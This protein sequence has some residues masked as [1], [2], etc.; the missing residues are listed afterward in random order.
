MLLPLENCMLDNSPNA[1][2]N[3]LPDLLLYQPQEIKVFSIDMRLSN[4]RD[5]FYGVMGESYW[6]RYYPKA[7]GHDPYSN[8]LFIEY[9]YSKN[10]IS[11][12]SKLKK[13]LDLGIVDY[14]KELQEVYLDK[15]LFR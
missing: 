14:M 6:D 13:I 3:M 1:L 4:K 9:L 8:Y 11:V 7:S 15:A 10:Y 2:Q 12:D 5:I